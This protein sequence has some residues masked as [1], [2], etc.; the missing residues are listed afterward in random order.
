[1]NLP[2][3]AVIIAGTKRYDASSKGQSVLEAHELLNAAGRSGRAGFRP[4]G[5]VVVITDKPIS[6]Q[7]TDKG[8]ELLGDF[9]SLRKSIFAKEDQCLHVIDPIQLM[10]DA[11]SQS[12]QVPL[13]TPAYF[14]N[15][16]PA[17][18][19]QAEK[20]SVK[21]LSRT[22]GFF[23]AKKRSEDQAYKSKIELAA[24]TRNQML[25]STPAVTWMDRL[26]SSNGLP[27]IV[28]QQ[29]GLDLS[30]DPH[31]ATRSVTDWIKWIFWWFG[32]HPLLCN[33]LLRMKP[34][35]QVFGKSSL[36][37]GISKS[38]LTDLESM[39]LKFIN[40]AKLIEIE[41]LLP[42]RPGGVG[43]C[44]RTRNFIQ[45]VGLD[46]SYTLGLIPQTHR[47]LHASSEDV[48]TPLAMGVASACVRAGF[49]CPEQLAVSIRL[50]S[51]KLMEEQTTRVGV[52]EF[53]RKIL[54]SLS[55]SDGFENFKS[56]QARVSAV[57]NVELE[58]GSIE[59]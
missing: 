2:A 24:A 16:L 54:P 41:S 52:H 57:V 38:I 37:K 51:E 11:I 12:Q 27:A 40:G 39:T 46:L 7:A 53:Y 59:S 32:K 23:L 25:I 22:L 47:A 21:L 14:L 45:S 43:T 20:A 17:E 50:K 9:H 1:M 4:E 5:I 55:P 56:L 33:R 34:L 8:K 31:A 29:L 48:K 10:L 19:R 28:F 44:H 42:T 35:E 18:E 30:A 49:C 6:F 36:N 15:R 26:A 58:F 13:G 3:E